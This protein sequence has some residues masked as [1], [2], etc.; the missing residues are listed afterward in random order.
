MLAG[1]GYVERVGHYQEHALQVLSFKVIPHR[2]L[3]SRS[4]QEIVHSQ[5]Y[6]IDVSLPQKGYGPRQYHIHRYGG[7]D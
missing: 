5:P 2:C 7:P 1:V 3:R 6:I 4:G